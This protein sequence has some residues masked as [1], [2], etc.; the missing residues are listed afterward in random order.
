[1]MQMNGSCGGTLDLAS[2]LICFS[3]LWLVSLVVKGIYC[4]AW[5][6]RMDWDLGYI[7]PAS[8]EKKTLSAVEGLCSR[9]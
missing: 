5:D 3:I 9:F 7:G 8:S 6:I 2:L 1:M 4:Y